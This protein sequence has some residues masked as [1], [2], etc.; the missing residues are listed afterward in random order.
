MLVAQRLQQTV[1]HPQTA[2]GEQILTFYFL[3]DVLFWF[4]GS[5]TAL[6]SGLF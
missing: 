5:Q 6:G 4:S 1:G 2:F 3:S